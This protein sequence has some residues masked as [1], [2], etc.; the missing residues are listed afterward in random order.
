M[1]NKKTKE[2]YIFIYILMEE[3]KMEKTI[4]E[5][6]KESKVV[7]SKAIKSLIK[8]IKSS[9][10]KST[11]E[12]IKLKFRE[13]IELIENKKLN[14][15]VEIQRDF[16][17]TPSFGSSLIITGLEG[18]AIGQILVVIEDIIDGKQRICSLYEYY[19]GSYALT[20]LEGD[21]SVLNNLKYYELPKELQEMILDIDIVILKTNSKHVN[22]STLF[23][24]VNAI[25]NPLKTPEKWNSIFAKSNAWKKAKSMAFDEN[26]VDLSKH[27][28]N[29]NRYETAQKFAGLLGLTMNY[30][31]SKNANI[32]FNDI[33]EMFVKES[34][35]SEVLKAEETVNIVLE[36]YQEYFSNVHKLRGSSKDC[37]GDFRAFFY[38][39]LHTYQTNPILFDEICSTKNST[40]IMDNLNHL[41]DGLKKAGE[42]PK[43]EVYKTLSLKGGTSTM[44]KINSMAKLFER[45]FVINSSTTVTSKSVKKKL[46]E[47]SLV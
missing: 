39:L 37:I 44:S 25:Q 46:S 47:A 7:E 32:S 9:K 26:F 23:N 14:Y 30:P 43:N 19:C 16:I 11:F 34:D 36:N 38:A 41:Y 20:N 6:K 5:V 31:I 2:K 8:K 27:L 3:K 18:V 35:S 12:L 10:K 22:A 29:D 15:D 4:K 45:F 28:K 13:V 40:I 17:A 21:Y 42:N 33:A 1:K 24:R